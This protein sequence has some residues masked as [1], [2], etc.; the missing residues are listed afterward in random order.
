MPPK[1][2]PTPAPDGN[3]LTIQPPNASGSSADETARSTPA[4]SELPPESQDDQ[5]S[6][7]AGEPFDLYTWAQQELNKVTSVP[8]NTTDPKELDELA[9]KIANLRSIINSTKPSR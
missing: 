3:T 7:N 1:R 5:T 6:T 2:K 9:K 4:E 8:P